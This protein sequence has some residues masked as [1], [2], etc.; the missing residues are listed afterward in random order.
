M[1][2][3]VLYSKCSFRHF[4]N[5]MKLEVI[6]TQANSENVAGIYGEIYC[7]YNE[8]KGRQTCNT[9]MTSSWKT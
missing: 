6:N 8:D 3:R 5:N 2:L 4:Y 9:T 7:P 1:Q